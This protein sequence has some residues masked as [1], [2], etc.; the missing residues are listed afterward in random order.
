MALFWS[1]LSGYPFLTFSGS[2]KGES[3][4]NGPGSHSYILKWLFSGQ[5]CSGTL[6]CSFGIPKRGIG[7]VIVIVSVL[8]LITI[9]NRNIHTNNG[10]DITAIALIM[11]MVANMYKTNA[12]TLNNN[13]SS[14]ISTIIIIKSL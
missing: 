14:N 4:R 3:A 11:V 9:S 8:L 10:N 7:I 6:F 13:I 5:G 12:L 1:G 2:R